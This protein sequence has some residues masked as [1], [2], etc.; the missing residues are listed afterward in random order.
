M[1]AGL[2]DKSGRRDLF[3]AVDIDCTLIPGNGGGTQHPRDQESR[4]SG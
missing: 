3:R 2:V 1:L 4:F